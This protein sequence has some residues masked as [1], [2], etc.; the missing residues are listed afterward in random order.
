MACSPG[1]TNRVVRPWL[2]PVGPW[3]CMACTGAILLCLWYFHLAPLCYG[4]CL[5]LRVGACQTWLLELQANCQ[6]AG[7]GWGL[8]AGTRGLMEQGSKEGTVSCRV[9]G[10]LCEHH[11]NPSHGEEAAPGPAQTSPRT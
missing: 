3:G 1:D 5:A 8:W 9:G 10:A 2:P 6:P 7:A 11:A 4:E